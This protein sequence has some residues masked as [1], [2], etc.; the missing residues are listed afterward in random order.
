MCGGQATIKAP[1]LSSPA[2]FGWTWEVANGQWNT[3]WMIFPP[4]GVE[5]LAVI[6]CGCTK[7]CRSQCKCKKADMT[8]KCGGC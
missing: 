5:C 4:A 8:C 2:D 1:Q 7:G 3:K 6:K